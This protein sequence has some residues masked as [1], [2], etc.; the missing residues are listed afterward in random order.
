MSVLILGGGG[1]LG[2][3]I[4]PA[5][6]TSG[7]GVITLGRS[8]AVDVVCDATET[9]QLTSHLRDIRPT[10]VVNL[11]GA[12]L[13]DPNANLAAMETV[14]ARFPALL[15]AV[16]TSAAPGTHLIHAASSTEAPDENGVFESDYSRSK[17]LGTKTLLKS[18]AD[19]PLTI[20]R[21]H[22]TYGPDQPG[23]RF[24]ASTID[25]LASGRNVSLR[26]PERARDFIHVDDVAHAFL[27]AVDLPASDRVIYDVGTG[28]GTSL[29]SVVHTVAE[30]V[31][32]EPPLVASDLP[33][34]RH[35][36]CVAPHGS[37]LVPATIDLRHGLETTITQRLKEREH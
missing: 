32:V 29:K 8:S 24:V 9:D 34:D 15:A 30:I 37:Q 13:S 23:Q 16:M 20:L 5:I 4:A 35:P 22:N 17:A 26:H 25:S 36:R 11:L 1:F 3:H 2:R 14:N 21:V 18:R 28:V 33:D 7:T 12:G 19:L 10:T 27:A 6:R 31:G